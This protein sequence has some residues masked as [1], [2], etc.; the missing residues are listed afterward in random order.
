MSNFTF[1]YPYWFLAL[2]AVPAIWWLN[3]RIFIYDSILQLVS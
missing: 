3:K 2:V 1:I